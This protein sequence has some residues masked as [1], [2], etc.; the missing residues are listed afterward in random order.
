MNH[1]PHHN[2]T[3]HAREETKMN[4]EARKVAARIARDSLGIATLENRKSD[5]LDFHNLSVWRIETALVAAYYAGIESKR[6]PK[7][8]PADRGTARAIIAHME[9]AEA[10]YHESDGERIA[11]GDHYCSAH[12][13]IERNSDQCLEAIAHGEMEQPNNLITTE[14]GGHVRTLTLEEMHALAPTGGTWAAMSATMED[15]IHLPSFQTYEARRRK[16]LTG[17]L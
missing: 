9:Q 15:E 3:H 13:R 11:D 2:R 4:L 6:Q 7:P 17:A 1:Q 12:D 8:T 14:Q 10:D 16:M 5:A